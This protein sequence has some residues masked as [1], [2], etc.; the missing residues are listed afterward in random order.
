MKAFT[1]LTNV[2]TAKVLTRKHGVNCERQVISSHLTTN[3]LAPLCQ[4]YTSHITL[5]D[6]LKLYRKHFNTASWKCLKFSTVLKTIKFNFNSQLS[7][8]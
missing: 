2:W 7:L 1:G 3:H 8:N 5:P 4:S 6:K